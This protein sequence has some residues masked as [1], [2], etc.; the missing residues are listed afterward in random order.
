MQDHVRASPH[1]SSRVTS[2]RRI[3]GA[4][5]GG[6]RWPRMQGLVRHRHLGKGDSTRWAAC[7][8]AQNWLIVRRLSTLRHVAG[9]SASAVIAAPDHLG[10]RGMNPA[11]RPRDR[12]PARYDINY[13]NFYLGF[14]LPQRS[15]PSR[16]E[17]TANFPYKAREP[18]G[19]PP[20]YV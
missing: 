19:S 7:S 13:P 2:F 10:R 15:P 8:D 4:M 1:R 17:W 16:P 12:E 18:G 5:S 20:R 14:T 6:G 11:V 9:G 3:Q